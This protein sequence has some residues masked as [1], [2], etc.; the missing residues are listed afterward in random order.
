MNNLKTKPAQMQP[1]V[2]MKPLW[3]CVF[4]AEAAELMHK[5]TTYCRKDYDEKNAQ[6]RLVG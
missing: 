2:S 5:G 3:Q 6:G 4:C 1:I